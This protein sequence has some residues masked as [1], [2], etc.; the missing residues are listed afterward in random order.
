MTY[1]TSYGLDPNAPVVLYAPAFDK[2]TALDMYG[3]Q[4]IEKLLETNAS[5]IVKLHP[6]CYDHRYYYIE[7]TGRSV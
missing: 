7:S 6:M 1:R 3:D 4:V 2:G 5:I